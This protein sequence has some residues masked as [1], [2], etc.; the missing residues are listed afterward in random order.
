MENRVVEM[1]FPMRALC[2]YKSFNSDFVSVGAVDMFKSRP[3]P[4]YIR[5]YRYE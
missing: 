5:V 3:V 2:I 4:G 1:D